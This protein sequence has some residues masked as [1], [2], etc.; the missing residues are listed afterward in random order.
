M[1]YF[2]DIHR[3][4]RMIPR[5]KVATYGSVARAA[6][7]PGTA[8]QVAWALN[9]SNAK[10]LPWHRVLGSGGR[11]LLPGETGLHQRTL[12]EVEGIRFRGDRVDIQRYECD[13]TKAKTPR[14]PL[15]KNHLNS[16]N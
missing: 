6:G 4:V 13:F 16:C 8:R 9:A 11:I 12:L 2:E 3:V 15:N 5:G 14:M 10:R 1:G 7:H